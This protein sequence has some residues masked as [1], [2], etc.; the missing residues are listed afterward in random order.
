MSSTTKNED[1]QSDPQSRLALTFHVAAASSHA[2]A[3][4]DWVL[5]VDN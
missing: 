4:A 1:P 3:V 5:D 2:D